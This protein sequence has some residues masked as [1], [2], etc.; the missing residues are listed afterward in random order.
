VLSWLLLSLYPALWCCLD[1]VGCHGAGVGV[2]DAMVEMNV[3]FASSA[4]DG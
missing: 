2:Y 4:V 1:G 3:G